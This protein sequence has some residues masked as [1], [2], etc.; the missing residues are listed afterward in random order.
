MDWGVISTIFIFVFGI[1]QT[2]LTLL[3]RAEEKARNLELKAINDG[4]KRIHVRI[5]EVERI[6]D[7]ILSKLNNENNGIF[8][9]LVK[10][11]TKLNELEK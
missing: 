9:R 6:Q 10:L 1:I 11:E 5:D 7:T 4:I 2:L 8:I 3:R